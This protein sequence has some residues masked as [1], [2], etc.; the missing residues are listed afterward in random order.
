MS[1]VTHC[2]FF[3]Q[4]EDRISESTSTLARTYI[5]Q[6]IEDAG[7]SLPFV[8]RANLVEQSDLIIV[9]VEGTH[10]VASN[11]LGM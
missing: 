6:L 7:G 8:S 10:A 9:T 4:L 2:F 5:Y 11:I 1:K 3:P